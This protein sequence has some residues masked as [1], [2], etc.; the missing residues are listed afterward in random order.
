MSTTKGTH[1]VNTWAQGHSVHEFAQPHPR[2]PRCQP[3]SIPLSSSPGP[4]GSR[5]SS[6]AFH[7]P[8]AAG[9]QVLRVGRHGNLKVR[10]VPRV[11]L[12]AIYGA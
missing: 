11:L 10:D 5:K 3:N 9:A 1:K 8:L 12:L 2:W 6:A 7:L 4:P